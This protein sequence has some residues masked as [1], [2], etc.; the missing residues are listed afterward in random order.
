MD[1][2]SLGVILYELICGIPPFNAD[3]VEEIFKNI[4]NKEIEWP[5]IGHEE[6]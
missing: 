3:T 4:Q 2:W 6:D 5:E 1:W